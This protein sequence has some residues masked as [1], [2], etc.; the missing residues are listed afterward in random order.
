MGTKKRKKNKQK[1]KTKKK[2]KRKKTKKK[3]FVKIKEEERWQ[4]HRNVNLYHLSCATSAK[5][6]A[7]HSSG[8]AAS[9]THIHTISPR[10]DSLQPS[11]FLF[12]ATAEE[13][14][15]LSP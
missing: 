9:P 3:K 4:A 1:K 5:F 10:P 15:I 11:S 7:V 13:M 2:H 8:S 6:S 12:A 14:S